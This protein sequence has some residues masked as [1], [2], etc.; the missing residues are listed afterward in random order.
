MK[1]LQVSV[2]ENKNNRTKPFVQIQQFSREEKANTN[3][4]LSLTEWEGLKAKINTVDKEIQKKAK[5][6]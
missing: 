3:L 1:A 6:P 5:N 2:V 4:L